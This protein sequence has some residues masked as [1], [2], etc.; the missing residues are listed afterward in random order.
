[1]MLLDGKQLAEQL[2]KQLREET[3]KL[4]SRKGRTPHLAAILVGDDPASHAYVNHKIKACR[5]CEI[6]SALIKLEDTISENE[7]LQEIESLNQDKNTDGIIVQ[8][9]LPSHIRTDIIA[10][11]ILPQKDVDGFHP[12]NAGKLA[13][14]LPC[15]IPAT[16]KGII[17]LLQHYNIPVN[18]KHVVI[19]G[20]SHLVG[21][22]LSILL[23]SSR[24]NATVTLCHSQTT[25]LKQHTT[26]AD[27]LVAAVGKPGFVT[28]DMVKPQ[29]VVIDVGINR[30]NDSTAPAGYRLTGD[31]DFNS[32]APR[33]HAITPVPGGVGPMTIIGLLINTLQA[34]S[35]Q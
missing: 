25:G 31:V 23:S 6:G 15:F 29:A 22:P 13:R 1:M 34:A 4:K 20:R 28:A 21:R 24:H 5:Q 26:S 35:Q 18:G 9:P 10:S 32:V 16:P 2:K 33:C 3:L 14:G 19:I 17:L 8:L 27:I 12:L 30:I 11:A 7:L